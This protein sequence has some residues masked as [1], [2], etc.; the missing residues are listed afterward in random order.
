MKLSK[1]HGEAYSSLASD[2][3]LSEPESALKPLDPLVSQMNTV[4]ALKFYSLRYVKY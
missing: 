1:L 3:F 2:S 4:Y